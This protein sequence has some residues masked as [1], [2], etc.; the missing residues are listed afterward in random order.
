MTDSSLFDF[1]DGFA[2][3]LLQMTQNQRKLQMAAGV[4]TGSLQP[5]NSHLPEGNHLQA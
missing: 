3:K 4:L 1:C 5:K 2:K